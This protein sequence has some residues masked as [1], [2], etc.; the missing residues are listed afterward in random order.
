VESAVEAVKQET[1][2]YIEAIFSQSL[3]LPH[4][5]EEVECPS[6][7]AKTG[8]EERRLAAEEMVKQNRRRT[9]KR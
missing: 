6:E 1:E 9:R 3:M 5:D 2:R 4:D 8:S 7:D